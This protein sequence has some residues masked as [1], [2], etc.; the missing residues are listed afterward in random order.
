[1]YHEVSV[2]SWGIEALCVAEPSEPQ[3]CDVLTRG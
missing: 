2:L 1:M 3:I